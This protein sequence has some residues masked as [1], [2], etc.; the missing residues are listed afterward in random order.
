MRFTEF[1]PF[2]PA[3]TVDLTLRA[4]APVEVVSE[5]VSTAFFNMGGSISEALDEIL[6]RFTLGMPPNIKRPEDELDGLADSI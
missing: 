2:F 1:P 3:G 6:E 4:G 5:S